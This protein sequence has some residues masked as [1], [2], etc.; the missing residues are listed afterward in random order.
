MNP[1][2]GT[3]KDR[4]LW[5]FA[6]AA[7]FLLAAILRFA[8]VGYSFT[9]YILVGVGI[10]ILIF[11]LLRRFGLARTRHV[12]SVLVVIGCIC[13]AA[14]ELIVIGSAR[15]DKDPEAPYLIV[16]GAGLNG[17][18]PSLSLTDRLVA[19][20][21]Y[22]EQYPDAVAVVTGGQGPGELITE[23]EAMET[24]LLAQG[25]AP[26][27]ILREERA[28]DTAENIT[29]S[30]ELIAQQGG[31]PAGR[32]AICTSEYHLYRA[33][34]IAEHLGAAPLGVAGETSLPVLKAN[35]FIREAFGVLHLWVFGA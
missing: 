14:L 27:R 6:M 2:D 7:C 35:Y 5:L 12:L 34:Y 23:A 29:F 13:F 25:I 18:A 9:A 3:K 11:H 28:T 15:T 33:K 19:A 26:E 8:L 10:L 20:R 22:L 16:L 17:T 24:W 30:L 31:D 21:E 4:R 1:S 32:V